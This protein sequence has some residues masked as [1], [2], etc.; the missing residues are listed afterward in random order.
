MSYFLVRIGEGSKY[1]EEG[2]KGGF[3]GIGYGQVPDLRQF[4]NALEIKENI[5]NHNKENLSSTKININAGRLSCFALEMQAGDTVISP[6]GGGEYIVGTVG[7]YYFEMKPTGGCP[8]KHRRKIS[9]RKETIS[10]ED[11]STNLSYALGATLTLFSLDNY[12]NELKALIAGES[13]TPADKLQRIRDLV[14]NGLLELGGKEFEEF[15]KHLLVIIGF[16]AETTQYVG[17]RNIDING[18]LNAE[19]LADI[20]LRIQVKRIR[21][22]VS[23]KEI[24]ALRGALRQEEHG[25]F[26]TLSTFTKSAIEEAQAEGKIPIKIIDGE[27][28][29]GLVLRHYDEI[30]DQYKTLFGIRKKKDFNIEDQFEPAQIEKEEVEELPDQ[31]GQK[32]EWDTIVCAA[33][34]D[35]FKSAFLKQKAWWAVRLNPKTIQF[36]FIS[37]ILELLRGL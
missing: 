31:I 1:V 30:D 37:S 27:D 24:L 25:C 7:D 10:K 8:Y 16:S 15:I 5:T 14:L 36:S 19:G 23:N 6:I 28:L 26:I 21:S 11:M 2:R 33:K 35:G 22:S 34:E 9:W 17:D 32:V 29:A 13:Y 18:T 4:K 3:I 20:T 12:A